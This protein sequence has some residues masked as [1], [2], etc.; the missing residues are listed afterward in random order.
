VVQIIEREEDLPDGAFVQITVHRDPT[1]PSVV[2]ADLNIFDAPGAPGTS[3][4]ID[5]PAVD[6]LFIR[7]IELARELGASVVWVDDPEGLFPPSRRPAV[8]PLD[9][10]EAGFKLPRG[11]G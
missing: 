1:V 6:D 11:E 9:P 7:A 3:S 2:L 5:D 8:S 10:G 4:L